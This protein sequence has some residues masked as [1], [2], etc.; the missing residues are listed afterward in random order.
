MRNVLGNSSLDDCQLRN[1]DVRVFV[2][3]TGNNKLTVMCNERFSVWHS[4]AK[5]SLPVL[6]RVLFSFQCF[7]TFC[8]NWALSQF[9]LRRRTSS[10]LSIRSM[11][12][13]LFG[14]IS[15]II[16]AVSDFIKA[17]IQIQCLSKMIF[18]RHFEV[19]VYNMSV[20]LIVLLQSWY[21]CKSWI[22]MLF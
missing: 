3:M 16:A 19:V 2:L 1:H 14:A 15:S 6:E 11:T 4:Q 20:L 13:L 8:V 22:S 5:P 10:S 21:H 9:N 17:Q 18:F 7:A 12:S